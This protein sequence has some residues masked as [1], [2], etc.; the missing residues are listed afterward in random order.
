MHN[1][2][3]SAHLRIKVT[4]NIIRKKYWWIKIMKDI[5]NYVKLYDRCQRRNKFQKKN[6]L[7]PI[8]V[9]IPFYQIG[10]NFV[11]PLPAASI[12]NCSNGLFH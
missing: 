12:H 6:E 10:I 2:K 3:L 4:Q 5:E 1:H 11:G 7:T 8:S 9:K